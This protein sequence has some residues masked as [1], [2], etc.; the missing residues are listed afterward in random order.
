MF[1]TILIPS[2]NMKGYFSLSQ[3]FFSDIFMTL[4]TT[5]L[6]LAGIVSCQYQ[7]NVVYT[8]LP[9]FIFA[10]Q[11]GTVDGIIPLQLQHGIDICSNVTLNTS[12]KKIN[13]VTNLNSLQKLHH[14]TFLNSSTCESGSFPELSRSNVF[15]S[16]F[17]ISIHSKPLWICDKKHALYE[18]ELMKTKKIAVIVHRDHILLFTKLVYSFRDIASLLLLDTAVLITFALL[19]LLFDNTSY[20]YA[21]VPP[22]HIFTYY[23]TTYV[24]ASSV[25]YGKRV[26]STIIAKSIDIFLM[27]TGM[28]MICLN[29]VLI[30]S[31]ATG[32]FHLHLENENI[33]VL[34][35]SY[36][37]SIARNNYP[38]AV[39]KEFET[40]EKV[41]KA[42]SAQRVYVGFLNG[43]YACW[44]QNNVLKEQKVHIIRLLD[45]E[46]PISCL[47]NLNERYIRNFYDCLIK[48]KQKILQPPA[49]Y[50]T[51]TCET[52]SVYYENVLTL[53]SESIVSQVFLSL[54]LG[55]IIFGVVTEI[56]LILKCNKKKEQQDAKKLVKETNNNI[57][58]VSNKKNCL[59]ID[60]VLRNI[61][62]LRSDI[63]KVKTDV[64]V[65]TEKTQKFLL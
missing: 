53:I 41:I 44:A 49:D 17:I 7:I 12:I 54:I 16:P 37:A 63:Q 13:Y 40:Y 58:P 39:V 19:L 28:I 6:Y 64:R 31:S 23:W 30:T 34:K 45:Y 57:Y 11:N 35:D 52:E 56:L 59:G 2:R 24:T 27:M 4:F 55:L 65:I 42:V 25:G 15:F 3:L 33:A 36:E 26:P 50:F 29:T 22:T 48:L 1:Q 5:F 46:I 62:T 47:V 43:D 8:D 9:P 21:G 60:K 51:K 61:D 32:D 18:F 10:K 20:I 38:E 14:I